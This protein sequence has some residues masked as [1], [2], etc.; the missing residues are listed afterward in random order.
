M[1]DPKLVTQPEPGICSASTQNGF[2]RK[3]VDNSSISLHQQQSLSVT[4][5]IPPSASSK[6][7]LSTL[8][9]CL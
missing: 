3:K 1:A 2:Q 5:R 9:P 4:A 8:A 7:S 6:I